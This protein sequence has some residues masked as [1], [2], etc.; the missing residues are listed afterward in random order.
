MSGGIVGGGPLGRGRARRLAGAGAPVP[1]YGAAQRLGGLAGT[2]QL[3]GYEVARYY[4]AVTLTDD[5][6]IGLAEQLGL[7]IRWRPLGVGFFHDGRLCSMSSPR[8][9]LTFPGLRPDDKARLVAFVLRCRREHDQ[10]KLDAEPIEPWVRRTA[11]RRHESARPAPCVRRGRGEHDQARLDAEPIEPWVRRTA[12][13]RLWE[14]LWQPLLD[15][16]FDGRYDD[17][18]ATYLWSRMRRTADTRDSKGR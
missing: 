12:G 1:V 5:R 2:A 4:P 9:L 17:L 3:G 15:S 10:A 11:G 13:R 8:E 18:P 14:R 16:K 6:V 7:P